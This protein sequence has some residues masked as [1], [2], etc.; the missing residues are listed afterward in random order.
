MAT[1]ARAQEGITV[2]DN[3]GVGELIGREVELGRLGEAASELVTGR[4]GVVWVEGEPGIGK[5]ALVQTSLAVV[6]GTGA[7][8]FRA[9]GDEL[10]QVLPLRLI[11][12]CLGVGA[13]GADEFRR[14]IVD[15]LSGY[16]GVVDAVLA[17]AERLLALVDRECARSPVALVG[18]DLQWADEASMAVWHRLAD[19]TTQLP[20]L[21]IGVCRPVPLRPE[22]QRL[23]H[24][25]SQRRGTVSLTLGPLDQEQV[26][27]LA[28]RRLSSRPGPKLIGELDRAAGNPLYVREILD[29]L[30]REGSLRM[31]HGETELVAPPSQLSLG[32]AIMGRLRFL[33]PPTRSMLQTASILD[34]RFGLDQL[35][36]V[37]NRP[38][39]ELAEM[40]AEALAAGVL[41]EAESAL[42]FRHSLIRQTLHDEVPAAVRTG[43]HGYAA[44]VLA[45]AGWSWQRVARHLLAAPDAIDG[46]VIDWLAGLPAETLYALPATLVGLLEIA[47][48]RTAPTDPRRALFTTRL[49]TVLRL[50][51]R[52]D[53]L[54]RVGIEA[55]ASISDPRLVGEIAWNLARA[56]R[57]LDRHIE[58]VAL[59]QRVLN[60]PDPGVPWRSRLRAQLVRSLYF[61]GDPAQAKVQAE[62]AIEEG[63]RDQDPVSIATASLALK[64][65]LYDFDDLPLLDHTLDIVSGDDPE[66]NSLRVVL[67]G[68]RVISLYTLGRP[69]WRTELPETIAMAERVGSTQQVHMI[70]HAAGFF[71]E[72]GDWDQS[73]L[74]LDQVTDGPHLVAR[75]RAEVA[76]YRARIALC[77]G[78][79]A[80]ARQHLLALDKAHGVMR[81]YLDGLYLVSALLTEAEGQPERAAAMLADR[82]DEKHPWW[83]MDDY[84]AE[85]VRLALAVG[86]RDMARRAVALAEA[87][88]VVKVDR[89]IVSARICRA[90]LDDDPQALLTSASYLEG[91]GRRPFLAFVLQ[92]AA[93]RFAQQDDVTAARAAF[94]QAVD[95]WEDLHSVFD[96]RRIQQRLRPY[97]IRRGPRSTHR[98]ALHGWTALTQT[99]REVAAS[100]SEGRSNPEIAAQ[101][102]ISRRTVETHV[103]RIMQ[104]LELR[105]RVE[106]A[107]EVIRHQ[108]TDTTEAVDTP[109]TRRQARDS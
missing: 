100:V 67:R 47:R 98:R 82:L 70:I 53:D 105:S 8:V 2:V 48:E 39:P 69:E 92:E 59:I 19:A 13:T 12:D 71:L 83:H 52:H 76:G 61:S 7:R 68:I 6:G 55:L 62:R 14:E 65:G 103:A 49:T 23:R 18:D 44:Q 81:I 45:E 35:A 28:G 5:S 72:Q 43:M 91:A 17:V 97:G 40:V 11:A 57:R 16:G 58:A 24:A 86:D 33:S 99:E 38:V 93:V 29:V 85:L 41:V 63:E 4:G 101:M 79:R 80:A 51:F 50:L 20:L 87:A 84:V 27:V 73:L 89:L 30:I 34:D 107:R 56:Y 78:D 108:T 3:L 60:G 21:L 96:V 66:S 22:V 104:K 90:M 64:G 10:T 106:V 42:T 32:A 94:N 54:V 31:E 109:N 9:A 77:R 26:A 102:V 15:L 37:A 1:G 36:R 25:V 95:I 75:K 88:A 74:Y 46:W